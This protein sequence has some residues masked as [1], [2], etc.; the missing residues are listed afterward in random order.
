[1]RFSELIRML[2]KDYFII[3]GLLIIGTVF[4]TPEETINRE[5]V[6]LTMTFAAVGDLPGIVLWS[7]SELTEEKKHIR[8]FIHFILLEVVILAYAGFIGLISGLSEYA[9]FA[10]QILVI[11]IVV[12][13]IS[14]RK[15]L[16]TA[17]KINDKIKKLNI[18]SK[19]EQV[20]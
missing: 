8:S 14:Y 18:L 17:N 16:A 3:F 9:L 10:V 19:K 4:L 6:L 15:D 7:R 11:Y 12:R 5:Y 1:M 13:F 20:S 2:V